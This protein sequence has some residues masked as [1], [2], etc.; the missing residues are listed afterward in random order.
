MAR[1]AIFGGVRRSSSRRKAWMR[2]GRWL[3]RCNRSARRTA[4]S[5]SLTVRS[6]GIVDAPA[7]GIP[8]LQLFLAFSQMALSGFGGV[9][10]FAYRILVERRRW[11]APEEFAKLLA[12]SQVMP[13][14]TI[15]NLS[16]AFGYRTAGFVGSGACLAGMIAAPI[17]ILLGLG[18]SYREFGHLLVV[19]HALRGMSA[20][21][22]GLVLA[23]A[24]K[25]G[26][27]LRHR[28]RSLA[29]AAL[30]FA[31]IGALRMPLIAVI[32]VLAPNAN[33]LAWRGRW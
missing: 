13:G 22:A 7:R 27:A 17:A 20:V 4:M 31:G 30:A 2:P 32:A 9:L 19:Q 26:R 10:P 28:A 16:V 29:L 3:D 25:M 33:V 15:C 6:S 18:M 21:A 1:V 14:P 23:T 12:F 11:L 24:V 8:P 5:E